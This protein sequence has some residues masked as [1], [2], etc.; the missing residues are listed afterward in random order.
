VTVV[1]VVGVLTF[2]AVLGI[3]R[4]FLT[5]HRQSPQPVPAS[6]EARRRELLRQLRDL[7]DDLAAGKLTEADHDRLAGP[8]EREAAALLRRGSNRG[9]TAGE[10]R[11]PG[12]PTRAGSMPARGPRPA[13]IRGT[14]RA[15]KRWQRRSVILVAL[16][17]AIVG[18]TILLLGA[19]TPR[20]AGETASGGAANRVSAPPAAS[21]GNP[22]SGG[23]QQATPEQLAAID[24]AV[25]GVK[26][27]PRDVPAHLGLAS[28]Y[29]AGGAT[30]LAAV[31]YLAV[32][33][34][35]PDNAEANTALAQLAYAAGQT[36]QA[37]AMLDTALAAHPN[38][39][40]ALYARG[41]IL[42]TAL[43]Q[44][45]AAEK[46]LNAYLAVAPFGAHRT[47]VETLLALA[48]GQGN[49]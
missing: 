15:P 14:R 17:G 1:L 4:P 43:H 31:E 24:A 18:V 40:E 42:L 48:G 2:A 3:L 10:N 47:Q 21:P 19:V 23:G 25:R 30:Q 8:V 36:Q 16:G 13:Q 35:E 38:Y 44:P 6:E 37:K 7:D 29:A 49:R 26:A 5:A 46:D 9:R 22:S 41:L 39:P 45:R 32:I 34:L 33:K 28:A 20:T 27:N 11:R 12:T